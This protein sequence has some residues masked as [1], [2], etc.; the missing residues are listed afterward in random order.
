M[1]DDVIA[2]I[3]KNPIRAEDLERAKIQLIARAIYDK[4]DQAVLASLYG[5]ALTIGLSIKHIR[6]WPDRIRAV[7]AEQLRAAAQ[8]WLDKKRSVTGY[9]IKEAATAKPEEK[10]S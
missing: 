3:V 4:D 6:S 7:G 2:D 8:N 5:S 1:I 10:R 9:L